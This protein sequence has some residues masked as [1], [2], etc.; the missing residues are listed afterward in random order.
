[1]ERSNNVGNREDQSN[2][3]GIE[4]KQLSSTGN[5]R[6]SLNR[7]WTTK[8]KYGRD[9]AILQP[10]RG[11]CSTHSGSRSYAV[12]SSKKCTC[13]MGISRIQNHQS[14]IQ[15]KGGDH[16]EYYPMLCTHHR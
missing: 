11:K 15:N 7:S 9:A 6:N 8:A 16:N 2:N 1:M 4:E 5:Q 3:N 12:Q 14:I 10:R 13:M